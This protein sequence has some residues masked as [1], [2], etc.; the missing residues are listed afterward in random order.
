[1]IMNRPTM[2][3]W[4]VA[5]RNLRYHR[6]IM[7]P[8]KESLYQSSRVF[9]SLL[10]MAAGLAGS[11]QTGLAA[12]TVFLQDGRAVQ[13]DRVEILPDRVRIERPSGEILELPR[14][15]VLSVHEGPPP[16]TAMAT[17]PPAGVYPNLSG[18]MLDQ[19]RGEMSKPVPGSPFMPGGRPG[20][21]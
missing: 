8:A 1:M 11:A 14:S 17:T 21:H 6:S 3:A 4:L 10:L 9:S 2:E 18:Q 7:H 16:G 19:L 12:D 15:D 5:V 13:A 20:S